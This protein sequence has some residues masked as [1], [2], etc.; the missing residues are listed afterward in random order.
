MKKTAYEFFQ[1]MPLFIAVIVILL[2][3]LVNPHAIAQ[4]FAIDFGKSNPE[5]VVAEDNIQQL[6]LSFS[7]NGLN[8]FEVETE[9]G[10]FNE[11]LILGAY[12]TGQPG[13]PKLP[14]S[15]KLI[16]I[17]FGAEVSVKVKKFTN[18]EYRLAD[19][20]IA[21]P[22]VPV[23]PSIRK[24][25]DA[26][27]VSFE[28][29]QK[30]YQQD[31]F[32]EPELATVEILGVM[33]G[34]RLA[35]VT[36]APV[37]Y[38]PA[39]GII[40]VCNDV[41]LEI[42]FTNVDEE[43]TTYIKEST[44]SPYFKVVENSLLNS[45]DGSGYPN[46][47]DLT[48]YPVKYLI[49]ADRMF[50]DDLQTFIE[51]KTMKGFEVII[52][53]TD[54]IGTSYS[55]IQTWIHDQYNQ[56]SPDNP[57]PSFLLL[58]GDTPQIPAEMGS[59]TGKMTDLYYASVDGDYFPEMYYGRFSATNSTQLLTQIA[60]TIY[61][62]KYEFEDPAYLNG[63]T[64]IA[65]AD[66]SWNPAVGQ[67]T[68]L[69][70][71]ENYFNASY[72]F[73][74][75][76]PYLTSPYT[77][78]YSPEKIAVSM[79]NYTAHCVETSWSYPNLSQ[80]AVNAFVNNGKYP[81]VIGNCCMSGDFGYGECIGETW[82]RGVNKGSVVYIGSSPSSYWV[83]DFYWAV[84]AF[85]IQGN[86]NGYVP[87][88]EETTW[89]IFDGP[90]VSDYVTMGATVFMGNLAVTEVHIQGYPSHASPTYYWQAYNVLG[91]PS[92]VPYF[93]EGSENTVS[94]MAILPIGLDY[95]EVSAEPGSYVG[96]SK[97]G[98]LHGSALVDETGIVEVE[99]NP[100]L[101][102]GMVDIVV[103]KPQFMPYMAEVPAAALVGPYVDLDSYTISD[104][105]GNNNGLAD[106]D[107][108]FSMNVTLIN[109]GTDPSADVTATI[110]ESDPYV[111]LTSSASQNFGPIVNDE[112]VTIDDA[113]SFTVASFVPDQYKAQFVLEITDGSDNWTSNLSITVQ[114][115][116][117]AISPD[118][119]IDDSQS[120]N[121]DGTLDPGETA[122]VKLNFSNT[123]SSYVA[124]I[125][126]DVVSDDPLLT[127]NMAQII[128][129]GLDAGAS[130]LISIE[131]SADASSPIGY[132][133]NVDLS[134]TAGP[135]GVYT[136]TQMTTVVIGLIP[137]Y[138]MSNETV[139]TCVGLF[140]DSGG[141]DGQYSNSEDYTMTFLPDFAEDMIK[142]DFLS[143][144]VES[145]YDYL[146]IYNGANT[147]SPEVE[148]SPFSATENPGT[149]IGLN[150]DGALT[151][152]FTSDRSITEDGWEAEIS[153]FNISG[154][155][156]CASNPYPGDNTQDV[157]LNSELSW[158]SNGALEF[159]V[160]FD[161]LPDPA[162]VETIF[163]TSYVPELMPNTTYYWKTI[164]KNAN[165]QAEDCP[166]WTFTTSGPEYFMT[167]NGTVTASNGMFYDSGG[168]DGDYG[169]NEDFIMTFEPT[170]PGQALQ[171]TFNAYETEL[172][173][174]YLYI[175]DGPDVSSPEFAGSPFNGTTGP[176][177]I[178]STAPC[179]AITF[180]F[181]SNGSV[182]KF[183]WEAIFACMGE[184]SCT[185]TSTPEQICQGSSAMLQ[186]T[187]SGG[188]GTYTCLWSP[189]Q[190]LNDPTIMNPIAT[191][192]ITTTYTVTISDGDNTVLKDYT[193][194]VLP[195]PQVD[196]GDDI[197]VCVDQTI[198]LDATTPGAVSY[199]WTPGGYTTPT[200]EVDSTGVG[201]GSATY[202]VVVSNDDD[203]DGKDEIVITFDD[204]SGVSDV[205][206]VFNLSIYP[207]P[208]ST[209]LNITLCGK[210]ESVEYLLLNYQGCEV[211][212]KK[213]GWLNGFVSQQLEIGEFA[214]GIYYL[215]LTTND[216]IIIRKIV[217]R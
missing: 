97:D 53:Y 13:T 77:G 138:L 211:Y 73:T 201:L 162:F 130:E 28:F 8:A 125:E 159:D 82:Q 120:G 105:D 23:Q 30:M 22:I 142:V 93:T 57:A 17:P 38:N 123:G 140:Y 67:P 76:Y 179:G 164:L 117:M 170:V 177:T 126:I 174:D 55:D 121:N 63:V 104:P 80:S 4:E 29:N 21:L 51:W 89:G 112:T 95:Y 85:P 90:F 114:A 94:H 217:I 127:I 206:G 92:L 202:I 12:A 165:G 2:E 152:R 27:E 143:F 207:N 147:S 44:F 98:V 129:P 37:S 146:H 158:T 65:G 108:D 119:I 157:S 79:I 74:D 195:A 11:I 66:G 43:L 196:L 101:S 180:H 26:T 154:P 106:Y 155:P 128:V 204:C 210:A 135:S 139:T 32:I 169:N 15:K 68:V 41:E 118:F 216:E 83:E 19:Y 54:E 14:A 40:K 71:T 189:P 178:I 3:F 109:V 5:V 184:L 116:V 148:G 172:N 205:S 56:G 171:F 191:P 111:S 50:E 48:K 103:T 137:E 59:S 150:V 87:T 110:T 149:C 151:F 60:K 31:F 173:Y 134:V 124:G 69:Y 192:D 72:G 166:V 36:V 144:N 39:K 16:E 6:S 45:L 88:Y 99:I 188:S 75:V 167:N 132:P 42:S 163:V 214:S 183:G 145:G 181:T 208:T 131:V 176:G 213:I 25:Q 81:I 46:N 7:Y 64:L 153:C 10:N 200:I 186:V 84:G 212:T 35:R 209:V 102:S 168:P 49:V 193:L 215:R 194:V 1:S 141:P 52:A 197:S 156:E 78:C 199:Y 70:G 113:Y 115:P 160:Y 198:L 20:G 9:R 187:P 190:T 133:V 33:R 175:H 161:V 47:P 91:D 61:Y 100:V 182:T 24:D 96:I 34:Y 107:E 86:N 58:V 185:I 18:T 62:E 136:A 122:L 203:C